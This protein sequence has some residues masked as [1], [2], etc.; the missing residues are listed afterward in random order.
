MLHVALNYDTPHD[1]AGKDVINVLGIE[2][3][4][5]TFTVFDL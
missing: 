3:Q 5:D 4:S 1:F 2:Y